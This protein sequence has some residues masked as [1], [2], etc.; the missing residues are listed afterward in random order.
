MG[1][2]GYEPNRQSGRANAIIVSLLVHAGRS[3]YQSLLRY[4]YSF[5]TFV[6]R[7][8]STK[9]TGNILTWFRN[10]QHELL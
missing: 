6:K 3:V 5:F 2:P 9:F 7:K 10:L 4:D 8:Q 1:N